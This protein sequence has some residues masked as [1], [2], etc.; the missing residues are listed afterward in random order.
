MAD[1]EVTTDQTTNDAL[2]LLFLAPTSIGTGRGTLY[3][4]KRR[5]LLVETT[6]SLATAD[7]E[8]ITN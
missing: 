4:K 5:I 3:G 1:Y 8:A 2:C 7:K 6:I